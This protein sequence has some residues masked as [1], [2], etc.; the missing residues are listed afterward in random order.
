MSALDVYLLFPRPNDSLSSPRDFLRHGFEKRTENPGRLRAR[1]RIDT[2]SADVDAD[3]DDKTGNAL[4][5]T[6]KWSGKILS[7]LQIEFVAWEISLQMEK[8]C[9]ATRGSGVV[10]S[11]Q[12]GEVPLEPPACAIFILVIVSVRAVNTIIGNSLRCTSNNHAVTQTCYE[13]IEF[14]NSCG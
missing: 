9:M 12:S 1:F 7:D 10:V 5:V 8:P 4:T 11:V 6:R 13:T 3:V 2:I 14:F